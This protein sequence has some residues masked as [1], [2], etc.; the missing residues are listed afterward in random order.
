MEEPVT[1]QRTV[2]DLF[3]IAAEAGVQVAVGGL[4][5]R[6]GGGRQQHGQDQH[7]CGY[8]APG[9]LGSGVSRHAHAPPDPSPEREAVNS[10]DGTRDSGPICPTIRFL[11][12]SAFRQV[13]VDVS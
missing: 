9:V 12:Y 7:Q 3:A 4:G 11:N 5:I 6:R 8:C 13:R 10:S 2:V 1:A